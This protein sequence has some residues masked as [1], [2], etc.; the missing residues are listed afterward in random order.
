MSKNILEEIIVENFP[1]L[2]NETVVQCRKHRVPNKMNQ[3]I[4]TLRH[5]INKMEKLKF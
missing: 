4:P 2:K 3:N 5:I 1:H